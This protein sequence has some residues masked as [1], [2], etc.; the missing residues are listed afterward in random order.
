[1]MQVWG[2]RLRN[3]HRILSQSVNIQRMKLSAEAGGGKLTGKI[4]LVTGSTEGIGF[5]IA[6]RLAQDGAHVVVSSRK[7]PKVEKALEQLKAENLD[8]SG[9]ACHVGKEEDRERLVNSTVERHGGIDILVSNA[10]VNPFAGNML[11]STE[12]VWD[13][14]YEINIK[15]AFLLI[16]QVVPHMEK[17]GGGSIVIVSSIAGFQPFPALGPYSIS[18]TALLGLTK[19]LVPELS[20]RNIRVNCLA[21]GLIQ[22]SF[23]SYLWSDEKRLKQFTKLLGITRIGQPE[24]C[25]GTVSFLC[26]PD[27]AYVTGET[28]VVAGGAPSRL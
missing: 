14:I 25:A 2:G 21:P 6:R 20:P 5:A 1:M 11:D 28:I 17:R 24:D 19:A 15:A 12:D 8:V 3:F 4:A 22:T 13:K 16:K 18:K 27:A 23:S 26:S 10:A 9:M 7:Q